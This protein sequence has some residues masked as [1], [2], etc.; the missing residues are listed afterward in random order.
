MT[1][2]TTL[3]YLFHVNGGAVVEVTGKTV[4]SR[5]GRKQKRITSAPFFKI[6]KADGTKYHILVYTF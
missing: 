1:I 4:S 3:T 6:S 5:K 2:K